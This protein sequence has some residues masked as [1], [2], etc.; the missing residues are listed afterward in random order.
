MCIRDRLLGAPNGLHVEHLQDDSCSASDTAALM[1]NLDLIITVDT[2]VAHLAGALGRPV[3]LVLPHVA[4]WRWLQERDDTPLY[5]TMR[6]FR[7]TAGGNWHELFMRVRVELQH[8]LASR[9]NLARASVE[10]T[11]SLPSIGHAEE[12]HTLP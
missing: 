11:A 10:R 3:W 7:Q 9:R 6:L 2:M 5:P 4:D 8:A 12:Q 1:E